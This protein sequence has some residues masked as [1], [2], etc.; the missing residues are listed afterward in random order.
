MTGHSND[1]DEGEHA[2]SAGE[3]VADQERSYWENR[4]LIQELDDDEAGRR[5]RQ[6]LRKQERKMHL[7]FRMHRYAR[8]QDQGPLPGDMV[9]PPLPDH[10]DGYDDATDSDY[11]RG[12]PE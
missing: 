10:A 6:R 5:D 12:W 1:Y 8:Q 9:L 7:R 4:R 3:E 11:Q 2:P